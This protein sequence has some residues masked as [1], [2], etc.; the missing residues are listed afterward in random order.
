MSYFIGSGG[1]TG[2]AGPAGASGIAYDANYFDTTYNPV[3]L[4]NFN[5][6]T[7]D[8]SG[9]NFNLTVS[10]IEKYSIVPGFNLKGFYLNGST[11][12]YRTVHD[13][14]LNIT[15]AL[16]IEYIYYVPSYYPIGGVI[17]AY[18]ASG[19]SED[20]NFIYQISVNQ[21]G[22]FNMFTEHDSGAN[23]SADSNVNVI[24]IVPSYA[25]VT[26]SDDGKTIKFYSNGQLITEVTDHIK[27]TGGSSGQ[28]Y[29]GSGIGGY[30]P[31]GS[32]L[33]SLKIL[34]QELS[35]SNILEEYNFVMG[36]K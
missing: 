22:V 18:A 24:T 31:N 33:F 19:E 25:A 7:T 36:S 20:T 29:V 30:M 28:L 4:W 8:S 21:F 17:T 12:L 23:D 14:L 1:G 26:R 15:G 11:N 13:D 35:A 32:V 16:T 3:G 5:G 2:P 34:N 9:N 6:V 27:P 10:G